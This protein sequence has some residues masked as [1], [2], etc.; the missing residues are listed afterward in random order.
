[1]KRSILIVLLLTSFSFGINAQVLKEIDEVAPF[2]EGFSGVKKDGLWGFIDSSGEL[3]IDYREDIVASANK[4]PAFSDGMCL[5]KEVKD[6]ITFYGYINTEG[7]IVI[8]AEYLIA[9]P[10][11]NG[12]ARVIKHYKRDTHDS[13]VLG[14]RIVYY[15]YNELLINTENHTV[16]V[17]R[18]PYN[19]LFEKFKLQ[20]N[21][22]KITSKFINDNLIAVR[23]E[24]NRYMIYTLKK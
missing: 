22:P 4:A 10:F 11:E 14:K 7:E 6:G 18:G 23:D 8:P 21:P 20:K 5:I 19:L 2:E 15:S 12:Y 9:T 24:D 13:N 3:V 1:M 17:L 16:Q